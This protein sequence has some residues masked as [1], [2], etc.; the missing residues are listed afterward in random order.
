MNNVYTITE[1]NINSTTGMGQQTQE[2]P[3][4][5]ETDSETSIFDI[6]IEQAR[7][8][9]NPIFQELSAEYLPIASQSK[10][11]IKIDNLSIP[12]VQLTPLGNVPEGGWPVLIFSH[13][14]GWILGDYP[15]YE[16]LTKAICFHSQCKIIF[17]DYSLSPEAKYPLALQQLW[18]S[19]KW[20]NEQ[21]KQLLIN[22]E[23]IG[24]IGDS[25]G[26]NLTAALCLF[27]N[28]ALKP[29][30]I[31]FQCLIYPFIDLSTEA[32]YDS[33]ELFGCGK[34]FL[35]K[36]HI[37]WSRLHY[38]TSPEDSTTAFVSPIKAEEL[39][40]LPETLIITAGFDPLYDEAN[41]FHQKLLKQGVKSELINF[42]STIHGFLS[43]TGCLDI[44][45]RAVALIGKK[46]K[47]NL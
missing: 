21:S 16:G 25:A 7:A 40:Y 30:T 11:T 8:D 46:I 24:V 5:F 19:L 4:S 9:F 42:S 43:F 36:E 39:D 12:I 44:G 10:Q 22:P 14:G 45:T 17:I 15:S 23:R 34:Y 41:S 1:D 29:Y 2:L 13:G 27:N 26:G 6:S 47:A 31:K 33:R 20:L 18:S 28:Q 37:D 3:A 38:L 32:Q 35:S